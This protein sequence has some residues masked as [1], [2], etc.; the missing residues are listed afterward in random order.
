MRE[1]HGGASL[2]CCDPNRKRP[3]LSSGRKPPRLRPCTPNTAFLPPSRVVPGDCTRHDESPAPQ[4]GGVDDL[5][6][7]TSA[8]TSRHDVFEQASITSAIT[9]LFLPYVSQYTSF[10]L[11]VCSITTRQRGRLARPNDLST[12]TYAGD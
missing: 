8:I 5:I 7:V 12:V 1:R 11:T 4:R 3:V 10:L 9:C 6:I 2:F